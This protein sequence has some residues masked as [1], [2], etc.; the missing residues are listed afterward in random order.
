MEITKGYTFDDVLLI[1]K[2]STIKSRSDIDLSVDLGKGVELD[3]PIISANMKTVTGPVMAHTIASLGGLAIL[4]RFSDDRVQ[5]YKDSIFKDPKI[6]NRIGVSVGIDKSEL[7]FIENLIVYGLRI[8]CVDV[9][10]GDHINCIEMVR[11]ISKNYPEILLIAGNVATFDGAKRLSEAG[12]DIVKVNI[13][14]GSTCSTRLEAGAGVPQ[15]SALD[16]VYSYSKSSTKVIADGGVKNSGDFVKSLC[17]SHCVMTGNL[18]AGTNEAP[19]DLVE[20]NGQKYKTYVGSS[21]YK[22]N[23]IE[24]VA[25]LV[26]A[27]GPVA[28]VIKK[29]M[30][31]L[32]SGMSYQGV[33]NLNDLRKNPKFVSISGA[34]LIESHPHDI[35]IPKES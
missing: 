27:K 16:N 26:P 30:E 19:G 32:R 10:H 11:E 2:H 5:D 34:G 8:I 20:V 35:I 33:S 4:H 1:P 18:L 21:T 22:A 23:H 15:L 17:F 6:S 28:N 25:G 13:G 31:G 14:A 9:A 12:A 29:L 7:G 24:G 3:I